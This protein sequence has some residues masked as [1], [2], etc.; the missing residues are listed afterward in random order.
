MQSGFSNLFQRRSWHL[1]LLGKTTR[2]MAADDRR[3][4]RLPSPSSPPPPGAATCPS[5]STK[6]FTGEQLAYAAQM[7]LRKEGRKTEA[8]IIKEVIVADG[9]DPT[10][11]QASYRGSPPSLPKTLSA[12]EALVLLFNT[13]MTRAA[14]QE[15]RETSKDHVAD[16]FPPYNFVLDAKKRYHLAGVVVDDLRASVPVQQLLDHTASRLCTL[17]ASVIQSSAAQGSLVLTSKYGFDGATGQ[18]VYR[19]RQSTDVDDSTMFLASMVPLR[20]RTEDGRV[21]WANPKPNSTFFCR[22]IGLIFEKDSKELTTATYVQLQQD[23]ESLT[24]STYS[25]CRAKPTEMNNIDGVLARP[26]A[27]DRTQHGISTLHCWIRS[28][29]M[30]LHIAYRLPFCEW[31]AR[32]EEKQRIVKEQKQRIQTEFRQC[33]GLLI[34]QPLPGGAVTTNDGNSARRFF[35]EH[36]TSA[37]ILGLDSTL[38]RRFSYL[39]RAASSNFHLDEERFGVYAVE[40]ARMLPSTGFGRRPAALV[41][42]RQRRQSLTG[43]TEPRHRH[44]P[45]QGPRQARRTR[46][47][48]S[49]PGARRPDV[50]SLWPPPALLW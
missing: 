21:I 3:R 25:I 16:I 17:Q 5:C 31:Q 10:V 50:W 37:D 35:L 43:S 2:W 14:Y 12:D 38:I 44:R 8:D 15:V 49:Q 47:S 28:M 6:E 26:I 45:A 23:V 18:Q 13:N 33:L 40:T 30:F 4:C 20:L 32:G 24:P 22:P 39:L 7:T 9:P 36:E 42:R 34:D 41:Q 1:Q 19:H 27:G 29:E 46:R 11:V 48:A